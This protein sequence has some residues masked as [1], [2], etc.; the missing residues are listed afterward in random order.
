[1]GQRAP[2]SLSRSLLLL[3]NN[4][5][6]TDPHIHIDSRDLCVVRLVWAL[7]LSAE[8]SVVL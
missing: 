5:C 1:M 3:L 7:S 6:P 2:S 8:V 4:S